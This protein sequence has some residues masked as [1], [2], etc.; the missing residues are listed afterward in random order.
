MSTEVPFLNTP[1]NA[2]NH[3]NIPQEDEELTHVGPGTPCGEYLRRYWQPITRSQDLSD[4]P[5]R[6]RILGEDLVVFKDHGGRVGL[7][8]LHCSHRGT[9]L[10]YG[11]I[12][13]IG[14]RCCYHG[15]RFGVDGQI[16]ET[17]GEP[18]D[19][20]L[21]D[22][23]Y[24]GAYPVVERSGVIFTYMGPPGKKPDFPVYNTF[25]MPGYQLETGNKNIIPCNWL[26]VKDNCMDPVHTT[27]LHTRV[28]GTQFTDAFNEIPEMDFLESPSGMVYVATRRVGDYAWVRMN[29]FVPPNVHQTAADWEEATQENVRPPMATTWTVP[30]DD[31]QTMIIGVRHTKEGE[32]TQRALDA[33]LGEQR[34]DMMGD[35]AARAYEDRQRAPGDYEAEVGQRP[36]AVHALEHL[37][38][39]D[40]GVI[41]LRNLVR[42]GIRDVQDGKDPLG[43]SR[44][45][46]KI[47][48]TYANNTVIRLAPA[49][50]LEADRQL[51]RE[52]GLSKAREYI[53]SP[54]F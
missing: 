53:E 51:L 30:V 7:L 11:L 21:K 20:T 28:S 45:G 32:D 41:M 18:P 12:C 27:F 40:R 13:D 54:P 2:Y 38:S 10:E 17:P 6:I 47:I 43:I 26:Q 3:R 48:P 24:H 39:T 37:A 49:D 1:Y 5:S 15:W 50:T 19:S 8:E 36:I 29:D 52:T 14:I 22:R 9:S 46:N 25:D 34:R 33:G 4:L 35:M 23:L 16:L 42:Q 31:D 44:G